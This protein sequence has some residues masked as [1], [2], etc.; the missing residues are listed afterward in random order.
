[1]TNRPRRR[2]SSELRPYVDRPDA[3][4]VDELAARLAESRSAPRDGFRDELTAHLAD[5]EAEG[6]PRWRPKH[7]GAAIAGFGGAGLALLA[8]AALGAT[9]TG[10]LG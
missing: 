7:P 8:I 9:G 5:L 6:D 10:P 4:S 2:I 1:V 3:E